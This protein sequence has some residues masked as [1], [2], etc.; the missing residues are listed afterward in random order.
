M[1]KKRELKPIFKNILTVISWASF[2][3]LL[4]V[5]AFLVYYIISVQLYSTKGEKFKPKFALYTIISPSMEPKIKVYDVIIDVRVDS[6]NDIK[7]GDVIT[8]TSTSSISKGMTVTHRVVEKYEENGV[9]KYRTKGD[10]NTSADSG[11]VDYSNVIGKTVLKVPQLGRIQFLL[12]SKGGWIFIIVIPALG[13]IIYDILKLF[14]LVGVKKEIE[15]S[16]NNTPN[17]QDP[18]IEIIQESIPDFEFEKNDISKEKNK[19]KSLNKEQETNKISD[20]NS[21]KKLN[22]ALKMLEDMEK[23]LNDIDKKE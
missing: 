20:D 10:N 3:L 22:E 5:G 18:K 12:A 6:P 15:K 17:D 9:V 19:S 2:I 16:Q 14:K 8:F 23:E 1:E 11:S 13:I 21:D 7:V 4:A